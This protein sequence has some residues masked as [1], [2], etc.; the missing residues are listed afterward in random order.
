MQNVSGTTILSKWAETDTGSHFARVNE[1][2]QPIN[3]ESGKPVNIFYKVGRVPVIAIGNS[4]GDRPMLQFSKNSPKS[5]QM[6]VDHDDSAREYVYDYERMKTMCR[7]NGWQEISM[8]NDFKVIF[9][10]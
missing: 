6:I 3:D 9:S 4:P 5:L 8:K 7:E 10:E 1:I 2:V